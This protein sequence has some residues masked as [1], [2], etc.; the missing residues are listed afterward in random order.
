MPEQQNVT[1][2]SNSEPKR[3]T[4]VARSRCTTWSTSNHAGAAQLPHSPGGGLASGPPLQP[5]ALQLAEVQPA[6]RFRL[7]ALWLAAQARRRLAAAHALF[8]LVRCENG[9]LPSLGDSD[10]RPKDRQS[11][12]DPSETRGHEP[13]VF[14]PRGAGA[15][16]CSHH[17]C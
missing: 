4:L 14:E 11:K 1:C 2:A 5:A 17:Y 7:A 6:A 16:A 8:Q 13:H 10:R 12:D 9:S 15:E 3:P